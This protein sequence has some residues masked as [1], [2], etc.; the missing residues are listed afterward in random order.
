MIGSY[1]DISLGEFPNEI[2]LIIYS[3]SCTCHC[4]WCFNSELLDKKPLSFKQMKDAIDEHG[5]FIT[6]VVFSGGEPLNNPYLGKTIRYCKDKG[7]KIKINTNGLVSDHLRKNIFLP[8][9]D[10][11]NISIKGIR[12][13]YDYILKSPKV[14]SCTP[15]CDTLEYSF[16]YSKSIWPEPYLNLFRDFLLN[17][18]SFDWSTMFSHKW[19]RPD[20]FTVSQIQTGDCLNSQYNDCH[21]PTES[22]C[23]KVAKMFQDVP[24]KKLI[25]ETKEFGR[26][27]V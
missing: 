10:Y 3:P 2:S 27:A 15:L 6:A 17:K 4:P 20:I 19:S 1:T 12:M 14:H 8:Y 16:V 5:D 18:I 23:I 13:N 21:V 22:E 24:K 11:M 9:V 26:K 7:L 25:V